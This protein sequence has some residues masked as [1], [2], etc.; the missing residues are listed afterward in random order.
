MIRGIVFFIALSAAFPFSASGQSK[1]TFPISASSKTLGYSP[2]WIALKQGFFAQQG[3]DVQ[4]VLV[5]GADTSTQALISGSTYLAA[6]AAD[7]PILAIER[8]MDL[9]IIGGVINGLTHA[10][11]GGKKYRTYEEL[12]GTV[13]GSQSLTSGITFALRRVLKAKGL[14]YP[15][16]YQILSVGGTPDAFAAL[17]A[18]QIAAAPLALPLNFAAEEL[19]FHTIGWY[20]EVLPNY[21]LTTLTVRRSWAVKNRP[22]L[23][24][25]MMAMA[26]A[27]RWL[28]GNKEAA[29]N[30]LVKEMKLKPDHAR[31]GWEYYTENRVWHPDADVNIEGIKTVGSIY[32]DEGQIKDPRPEKYLDQ[33]YLREALEKLGSAQK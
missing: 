2:P 22:L 18:G 24:R 26:Q 7:V 33:S 5:R 23:V 1:V 12:R 17:A 14:Q 16:D 11:M 31:K 30:F 20:R 9:V 19:G 25:F 27:N 15:K 6:G 28:Y 3:L 32:A 10:I 13:L 29:V 8:G 4:L 21:Q